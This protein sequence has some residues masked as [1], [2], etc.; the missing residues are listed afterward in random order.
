MLFEIWLYSSA[1]LV[2]DFYH[3]AIETIFEVIQNCKDYDFLNE[4][5]NIGLFK[6]IQKI[7][8]DYVLDIK[9]LREVFNY[10]NTDNE[11]IFDVNRKMFKSLHVL[12]YF[13]DLYQE[14]KKKELL[15]W[16]MNEISF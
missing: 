15:K 9:E 8:E 13:I 5:V 3:E 2:T 12:N 1:S 4:L 14:D 11:I 16:S 7:S 10:F 6:I